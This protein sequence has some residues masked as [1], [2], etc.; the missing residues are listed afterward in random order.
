MQYLN[1]III[2]YFNYSLNYF[3]FYNTTTKIIATDYLSHPHQLS[4]V[5][6]HVS[7]LQLLVHIKT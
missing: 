3:L 6:E 1:K 5:F 4:L 7:W 2:F